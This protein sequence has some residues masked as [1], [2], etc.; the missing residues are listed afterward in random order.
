[1]VLN[2]DE[3]KI[4]MSPP[5]RLSTSVSSDF[6]VVLLLVFITFPFLSI[7]FQLIRGVS[8][9]AVIENFNV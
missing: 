2:V 6:V 7:A 1:M 3:S 4:A 8:L 9:D 5:F